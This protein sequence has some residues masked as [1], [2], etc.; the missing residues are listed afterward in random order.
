[1]NLFHTLLGIY[2]FILYYMTLVFPQKN[3]KFSPDGPGMPTIMRC[4]QGGCLSYEKAG[5]TNV[6]P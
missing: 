2:Y 5:F 1:M 4:I 6:F 3:R